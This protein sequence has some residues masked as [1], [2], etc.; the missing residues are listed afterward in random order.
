MARGADPQSTSSQ[1]RAVSGGD[2][3]ADKPH[4]SA[5][6]SLQFRQRERQPNREPR[7]G[8]GETA[9]G[10]AEETAGGATE[11]G[12]ATEQPRAARE[13]RGD[14]QD[15]CGR[16]DPKHQRADGALGAWRWRA[17]GS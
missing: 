13:P 10:R 14:N 7:L 9:P 15:C 17:E 16:A 5:R 6:V 1:P 11:K 4:E 3:R 2:S 8:A 12:R